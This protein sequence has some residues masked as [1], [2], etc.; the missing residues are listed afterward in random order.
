M[1]GG[2]PSPLR[3]HARTALH[4][5]IATATSRPA[6][7]SSHAATTGCRWCISTTAS[8]TYCSMP[9]GRYPLAVVDW[10]SVMAG[11]PSLDVAYFI[12]LCLP[13]ELRV[14][15][16]SATCCC[17]TYRRAETLRRHRLRLRRALRRLPRHV[18]A[19]GADRD[20]RVGGRPAPSAATRCS[21][22]Q[23]RAAGS[24]RRTDAQLPGGDPLIRS[25]LRP[26]GRGRR[27]R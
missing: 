8:T 24:T 25:A 21:W 23:W 20:L 13:V 18:A 1:P 7:A 27:L 12:G 15:V 26:P 4:G 17:A 6:T 11:P 16:T 9:D 2:I 19:R 14:A 5:F 22:R 3:R 10:Q